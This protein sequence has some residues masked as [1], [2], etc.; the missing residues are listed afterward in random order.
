MINLYLVYSN[1]TEDDPEDK[2]GGWIPYYIKSKELKEK[3][4]N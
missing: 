4:D 3:Q 2:S 1:E